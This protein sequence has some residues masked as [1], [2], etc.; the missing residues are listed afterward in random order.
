[1]RNVLFIF[2]LLFI[3]PVFGQNS[4]TLED[5]ISYGIEHNIQLRQAELNAG[6]SKQNYTTAKA[7]V[8]P[9]LNAAATHVYNF[10]QTIDPFTNQ[11][12]NQRVRSNSF[13]LRS[14][15][16]LFGGFQTL[17]AIKQANS[18][19]L[20]SRF[21]M[22][23]MQNDIML[24]IATSYLQLLFAMENLEQQTGQVAISKSQTERIRNLVNAGVLSRIKLMEV[25][26]QLGT[27]ELAEVNAI[28]QLQ[29]MKLNLIQLL[30]LDLSVDSFNI[31]KP[32]FSEVSLQILSLPP[33]LI[34]ENAIST[35]P[36]IKSAEKR[37]EG[38][39]SGVAMSRGSR[40]PILSLNGSIGSGYS[41]LRKDIID[42][43]YTGSEDV[44]G[45]GIPVPQY[46]YVTE[47]RSFSNQLN[48]NVNKS[49]G[50]NLTI[51]LFNRF[52]TQ[53]SINKAKIAAL[54]ADL[55][56]ELAKNQLQQDIQRAHAD[57]KAA[58]RKYEAS[59]KALY[60]S[61][62][63][64][65]FMNERYEQGLSTSFEWRDTKQQLSSAESQL[66]QSKYDLIFKL[67][68]LEFYNGQEF[69]LK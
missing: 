7:K 49:I 51:P 14:D 65:S 62:E 8:L 27:D 66:L 23:K 67:K 12:A 26:T 38:A 50:F 43:I 24:N 18:E 46:D 22:E 13:G 57:A 68:I 54:N 9:N 41:G 17:N 6:I 29:L 48:D 28:N 60:L 52:T 20:A 16:T 42:T 11:F 64:F 3:I 32:L 4:W 47:T 37:S 39:L 35:Q 33:Q 55:S 21:D 53:T 15:V 40:S 19:Y 31:L 36:Q 61:K 5:C 56:L 34:Y 2:F 25:E 30:Q 69:S 10:G 44:F 1:M 59:Q 63:T 45:I 58:Q